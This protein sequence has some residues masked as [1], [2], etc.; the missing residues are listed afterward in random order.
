MSVEKILVNKF[1]IL[2]YKEL[3]GIEL[4]LDEEPVQSADFLYDGRNCAVLISNKQKALLGDK[5]EYDA[6]GNPTNAPADWYNYGA[7]SWANIVTITVKNTNKT[8]AQLLRNFFYMVSGNASYQI[9][10]QHS[11]V[12]AVNGSTK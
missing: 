4:E 3:T 6:N 8:I 9:A 7:K 10:A 11:G 1:N 12:V 2:E 5:V